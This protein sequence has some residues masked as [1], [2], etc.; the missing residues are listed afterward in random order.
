MTDKNRAA[1]LKPARFH[2]NCRGCA[3]A[4]RAEEP[5]LCHPRTGALTCATCADAERRP[6]P[7]DERRREAA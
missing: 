7:G 3:R 5:A 4:I 6:A 1:R 2:T